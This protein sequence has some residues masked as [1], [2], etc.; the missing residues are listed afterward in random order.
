MKKIL[1]VLPNNNL[2]GAE[3]ILKMITRFYLKEKIIIYF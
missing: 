1:I 2:G 3:N